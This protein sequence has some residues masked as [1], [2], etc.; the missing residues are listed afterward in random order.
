MN[1]IHLEFLQK[2]CLNDQGYVGNNTL[3][4]ANHVLPKIKFEEYLNRRF[5]RHELFDYCR[6]DKNTDLNVLIAILSWGGM[7]RD[8][9]RLLLKNPSLI[10]ELVRNLR[11]NIY[12]NRK[13]AFSTIKEYRDKNLLPGLGIGYFTKLIC[14]LSPDLNGYIMDQWVAKSINLLTDSE[15]VKLTGNNWVNDNN[16]SEIYEVFCYQ[17]DNLANILNCNGFQAEERIF[18]VGKGKGA[19]RNYL[20][21]K[22]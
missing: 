10:I 11:K 7:R 13:V 9:G 5:N 16:T 3:K 15:I 18:S 12:P 17:I 2:R 21:Q 1:K 6:D 20:I 14:F 22:Y 4:W 8:H 19:W